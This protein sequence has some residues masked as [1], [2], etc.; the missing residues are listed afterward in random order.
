MDNVKVRALTRTR[1]QSYSSNHRRGSVSGNSGA[2]SPKKER[3]IE[4]INDE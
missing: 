4:P 3:R 1:Q 2:R